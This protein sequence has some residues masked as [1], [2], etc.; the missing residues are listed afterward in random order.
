MVPGSL[1]LDWL[2]G[3]EVHEDQW[4]GFGESLWINRLGDN[5]LGSLGW[6]EGLLW[7]HRLDSRGYLLGSSGRVRRVAGRGGSL[8]SPGNSRGMIWTHA[9]GGQRGIP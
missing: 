1:R 8:L 3:V 9:T 2:G 5:L 6:S 7:S 4:G